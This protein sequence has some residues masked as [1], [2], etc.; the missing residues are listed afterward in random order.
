M[1][2]SRSQSWPRLAYVLGAIPLPGACECQTPNLCRGV[3]L[4]EATGC[5]GGNGR[6]R[7]VLRTGELGD[8]SWH[9]IYEGLMIRADK[10]SGPPLYELSEVVLFSFER[11]MTDDEIKDMRDTSGR[12]S[13]NH[14]TDAHYQIE[15]WLNHDGH[16]GGEPEVV[17]AKQFVG[18]VLADLGAKVYR[19]EWH[20]YS[21]NEDLA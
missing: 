12:M 20:I 17:L 7:A 16:R 13:A 2:N 18:S 14:G 9:G 21:V 3:I 1:Q 4:T 10:T 5:E 6:T 8:T 11:E 19:T 15:L